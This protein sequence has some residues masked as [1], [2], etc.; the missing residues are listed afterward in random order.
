MTYSILLPRSTNYDLYKILLYKSYTNEM[1]HPLLL[2]LMQMLWDR[3]EPN[4]YAHVMTD[5][6]PPNTP[7][8]RIT[9]QIAVGDHQVSNYAS[10]VMARTLDMKTNPV[11][12]D[13]GRWPDYDVLWN[14]PR[15]TAADYPYHGNNIIYFDGGPPRPDPNN[16]SKTIG[17]VTPP[18]ENLPNRIAQDPHGAPGGASVAVALTSSFLQPNGYITDPCSPHACYGD[19]WDGSLP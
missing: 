7:E 10:E 14:V 1:S 19:A 2:Q 13:P 16:P 4:G 5:N 6:P 8:H 18:F 9:L 17:T 12:I 15:L 3:S 11:P